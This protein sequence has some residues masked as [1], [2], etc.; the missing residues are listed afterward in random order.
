MAVGFF[1]INVM[2]LIIFDVLVPI[3]IC[4]MLFSRSLTPY[5]QA[6]SRKHVFRLHKTSIFVF[7]ADPETTSSSHV[8]RR[9][10]V[11]AALPV[12]PRTFE[13]LDF[14]SWNASTT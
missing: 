1:V 4:V 10:L 8:F 11:R 2:S 5:S 9:L 6:V 7:V 13:D 12:L 14:L 3:G